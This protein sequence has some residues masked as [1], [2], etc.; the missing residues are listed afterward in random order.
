MV[1]VLFMSMA[2][3][4]RAVQ[5]MVK[6]FP[7][8]IVTE[9][10]PELWTRSVGPLPSLRMLR[11]LTEFKPEVI[12]A[13]HPFYSTW[14]AKLYNLVRRKQI[15]LVTRLQGDHWFE[16]R[17]ELSRTLARLR[18][19]PLSKALYIMLRNPY[20]YFLYDRTVRVADRI[21]VVCHWMKKITQ[22]YLTNKSIEVIHLAI[23]PAAFFENGEFDF[24][25]P[26]VGLVQN[27]DVALKVD[28]LL[29]F[30]RIVKQLD[31][32]HFYIGGGGPYFPQVKKHFNNLENVHVLGHV[33]DVRR[34]YASIDVYA[35][36]SGLDC[37]P[38][39]LLEASYMGKPV[40]GSKVGGIP[41]IIVDDLTGWNIQN[42]DTAQW[43]DKISLLLRDEKLAKQMGHA[44]RARIEEYF[45]WN[46]VCKQIAKILRDV[47]KND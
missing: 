9:V 23:D 20:I 8:D 10:F 36:A 2:G 26:N 17:D 5:Q 13:D 6:Y 44:G 38:T 27:M 34:F 35:L 12:F 40:L 45:T 31:N 30:R 29:A 21:I 14:Y 3:K 19:I 24:K 39:T 18:S 46:V 42:K 37:C 25:H 1:R 4:C 28:G 43:V 32:V 41:E 47:V 15:R 11:K 7:T 22:L 16:F 33:K